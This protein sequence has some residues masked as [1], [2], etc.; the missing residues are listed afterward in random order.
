M[1]NEYLNNTQDMC[2]D[3]NSAIEND[4]QAFIVLDEGD[5]NFVVTGFERGRF[6]GS[7]KIP[8]CNKASIT[9]TVPT[10]QG[11]ATV[12]FDII[13]Y[14]SL[15]WRIS[16]FFRCI[17]QKKNGERVVMDWNKV[18][19][20]CGRA[21]FKPRTYTNTHGEEKTANDIERFI[22]YDESFFKG[23]DAAKEFTE[24]TGNGAY[25]F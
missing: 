11:N 23:D 20:S 13:L 2:M 15:E 14:R 8:P 6:P 18:I 22:D 19:G 12:K 10:E 21:H 17:G 5:Y 24:V 16:A 25:P 3:W 4:G 7:A 9:A 1:A